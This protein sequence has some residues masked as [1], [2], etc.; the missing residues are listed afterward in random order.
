MAKGARPRGKF[1]GAEITIQIE[2]PAGRT[3]GTPS[4]KGTRSVLK[5]S[6]LLLRVIAD[7]PRLTLAELKKEL[8]NAGYEVHPKIKGDNRDSSRS[9]RGTLLRVSGSDTTGYFRVW[10]VPKSRKKVG[11]SW[12]VLG[13]CSSRK[14]LLQSR[15][16]STS[17][18]LCRP[19]SHGKAAKKAREFW[20]HKSRIFKAKSRITR[21]MVRKRI[22][23]RA[24][25]RARSRAR[26]RG[27]SRARSRAKA[28]VCARAQ[29]QACARGKEQACARTRT[30][31]CV[32]DQE[33]ERTN[34]REE[35][36][37]VTRMQTRARAMD[38]IRAGPSTEDGRSRSKNES[39][40]NSKSRDEKRQQPERVVKRTI[41]KPAVARVNSVFSLQGKARPKASAKSDSPGC[42]RNP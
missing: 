18:R 22:S 31:E 23:S 1:Q 29:E 42:S 12:L 7:Q 35:A 4:N 37:M 24:R 17:P 30:Q 40:P 19:R 36:H 9:E 25:P 2:E 8:G 39:R 5:V 34:T 28:Q 21:S 27:R 14:T 3:L 13:R 11:R 33:Q 26:S 10:K 20:N 6:Q 41:Q 32:Q 15:S 38:N 16:R